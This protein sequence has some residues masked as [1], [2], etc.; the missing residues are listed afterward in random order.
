MDY[1]II[2]IILI[3][4][5]ILILNNRESF[6]M[7]KELYFIHIPKNAGSTIEEIF[8]KNKIDVGKYKSNQDGLF[9]S[10]WHIP[11]KY[12]KNINF[13]DYITFCIVRHP[14]DRIVSE[15]NYINVD[16]INEFIQKILKFKPNY[17]FD[18]HLI[19]QSEY[20]YDYYGNKVENI[21]QFENF[22]SEF[23]DFMKKY[24]L[25]VYYE[26]TFE[27]ISNKKFNINDITHENLLLIKEYY[28]D[29]FKLLE[30]NN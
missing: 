14:I 8:K 16:D 30:K 24:K 11:P 12:N 20:I 3:I 29:D 15:A 10:E 21:I 27:N 19:P 5:I 25:D 18:C 6:E 17:S 22:K 1:K 26:D 7:N 2:L 23:K 13:K 28:K 4:I 9:C